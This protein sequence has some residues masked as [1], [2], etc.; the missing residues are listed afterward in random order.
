MEPILLFIVEDAFQITNR[1]CVLAPGPSGEAGAQP[2][3]I[4]DRLQLRKPD[5]Q[6]FETVIQGVEMLGRPRQKVITAP[7]LLPRDIT[8]NDVPK[9]TEV[10]FIPRG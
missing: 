6:S 4:G 7:I 3:R 1:G 8:K 9:G 2:L 5:G 10:W